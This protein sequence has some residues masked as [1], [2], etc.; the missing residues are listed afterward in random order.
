MANRR[1]LGDPTVRAI[2]HADAVTTVVASGR[3][4]SVRLTQ[5]WRDLAPAVVGLDGRSSLLAVGPWVHR[6]LAD[7]VA[8]FD[9]RT[10]VPVLAGVAVDIPW[11]PS[12][13]RDAAVSCFEPSPL[14]LLVVRPNVLHRWRLLAAE[15]DV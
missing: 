5:E 9:E 7:V 2:V 1:R 12:D 3:D 15:R 4:R 11:T 10:G 6:D 13:D 8:A 14:D